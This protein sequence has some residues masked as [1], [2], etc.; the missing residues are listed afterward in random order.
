MDVPLNKKINLFQFQVYFF[1]KNIYIYYIIFNFLLGSGPLS[2]PSNRPLGTVYQTK[3]GKGKLAVI[4]SYDMF[5][6]E[7]FEKEDNSKIFDFLIKFFL[8]N[9]VEFGKNEED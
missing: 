5:T 3:N 9:E 4:G 7:Y 8:G 6:D 2:Y 1:K